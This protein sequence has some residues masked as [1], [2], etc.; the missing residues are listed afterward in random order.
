MNV[1]YLCKL[2]L[3]PLNINYYNFKIIID[4]HIFQ[5]HYY[6]HN[7]NFSTLS[8]IDNSKLGTLLF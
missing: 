1:F 8:S 4:L 3:K 7:I 5:T 2:R 6:E